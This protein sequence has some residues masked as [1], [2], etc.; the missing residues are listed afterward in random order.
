M[1]D[2]CELIKKSNPCRCSQWISFGIKQGWIK[3]NQI[4]RNL[5]PEVNA[6]ALSEVKNL[7]ALRYIYTTLYPKEADDILSERIRKGVKNKEWSIIS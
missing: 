7:K 3:G 6:K 5:L 4:E 1:K 2:R